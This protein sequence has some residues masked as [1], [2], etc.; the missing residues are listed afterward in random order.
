VK[1]ILEP[2]AHPGRLAALGL[3]PCLTHLCCEHPSHHPIL[4]A[5]GGVWCRN[6]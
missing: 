4:R 2:A 1:R 5:A 6:T 3:R